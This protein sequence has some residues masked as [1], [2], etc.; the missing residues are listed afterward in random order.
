VTLQVLSNTAVLALLEN[1]RPLI[2]MQSNN[3]STAG[4]ENTYNMALNVKMKR[5]FDTREN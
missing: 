1:M 3:A 2:K 4:F 5:F